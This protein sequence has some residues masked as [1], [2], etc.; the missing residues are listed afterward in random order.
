MCTQRAADGGWP[1]RIRDDEEWDLTLASA[2]VDPLKPTEWPVL[3]NLDLVVN[4]KTCGMWK[5]EVTR[6]QEIALD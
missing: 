4:T 2:S 1:T 3:S 5:K 6:S